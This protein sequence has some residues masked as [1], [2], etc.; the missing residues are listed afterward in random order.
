MFLNREAREDLVALR[1]DGEALPHD[2]VGV[3][4]RPLAARAPD[5]LAVEQDRTALPA[6]KTGDGI[7]E[8]GL[9]VAVQPHD[10]DTLTGMDDEVEVVQH[11]E[12]AIAGG[13]S[14]NLENIGH[15]VP[16]T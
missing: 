12:R 5:L 9:A 8:R 10:S 6:G 13:Q 14:F 11:A 3:A 4:A 15:R 1:H 7:E 2:L 16:R